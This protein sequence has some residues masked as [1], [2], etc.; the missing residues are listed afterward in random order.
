MA[1]RVSEGYTNFTYKYNMSSNNADLSGALSL[2]DIRGDESNNE[3]TI[4][5]CANCGKD[6]GDSMNKC[7]KCDLVKYCNAAFKK[8][9]KSKHKKKCEKRAAELYDERLFEEPPPP[10]ECPIC[11]LPPPLYEDHTG[12]T[13]HLCCGKEICNGCIYAMR[14]TGG[15]NMKLCPFCKTSYAISEEEEV[16]RVMKLMEKGNVGAFYQLAGYYAQGILGM[17]QDWAKANEL[18]LKAGEL[19]SS[20]AYCNLGLAYEEGDGVE[21]DE[22][23]A[24]QYYELAAMNGD[25]QAR[26]NLGCLEG[27]AGNI[28]RAY[29]HLVLAA[30]AGYTKSLDLVKRGFMNGY[31]TKEEYAK[32][33]REYQKSQDEMKSEMRD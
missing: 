8:K 28:H 3:E 6:G 16:K 13:F 2:L 11:M 9:Y 23:K 15:K 10:E 7:N 29:K 14:E 4:T 32:T 19:G 24:T 25:I 33:L 12:I 20:E 5:I 17:S 27:Q 22:K 21:I 31:I 1:Q 30:R 26:H 18:W